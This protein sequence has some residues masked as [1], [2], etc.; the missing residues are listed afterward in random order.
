M[1]LI[2]NFISWKEKMSFRK[3]IVPCLEDAINR[4]PEGE[5]TYYDMFDVNVG[6]LE[7]QGSEWAK[8]YE[9]GID[10]PFRVGV[11]WDADDTSKNNIEQHNQ[12]MDIVARKEEGKGNNGVLWSN[13]GFKHGTIQVLAKFP[14][15]EGAFSAIWMF[16]GLPEM[17][18]EHCGQWKN[19]VTSTSHQG[20]DYDGPYGKKSTLHNERKNR[21]FK[22]TDQYYLYEIYLSP[23]E[24]I[25]YI[26]GLAVRKVC[27]GIS[28]RDQ[29]LIL[30]VGKG[31][32]CGSVEDGSLPE[33]AR[34]S[35]KWV[36]TFKMA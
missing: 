34:M 16:D 7:W 12:K 6:N 32:Y 25:W 21:K 9:P 20:F 28:N 36:R 13:W 26:N 14:N 8:V 11:P 5:I 10:P 3:D 29:H 22:P 18:F 31:E 1:R 23:Y 35:V 27:D 2:N 17:D 4:V 24:M 19:Q 15:I 30:S 33:D